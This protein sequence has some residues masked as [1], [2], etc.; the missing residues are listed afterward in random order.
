M[1]AVLPAQQRVRGVVEPNPQQL[2]GSLPTLESPR[3]RPPTILVVDDDAMMRMLLEMGL[4]QQGFDVCVAASGDEA[5]ALYRNGQPNI[6]LVLLD[7]RMPGLDGPQTLAV[8]RQQN[9]DVR[10][11]FVSG[12]TG[13][14]N[15]AE[16]LAMG[17]A[18]V[19]EKPF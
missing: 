6:D 10:C 18:D 14:Y 13:G 1:I 11:C 7:V 15:P 4:R 12:D 19:I 16:L 2:P 9:P 8:L 17:V 3:P 5:V